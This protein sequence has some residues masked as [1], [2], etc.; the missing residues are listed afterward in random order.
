MRKPG[1]ALLLAVLIGLTWSL[2]GAVA[3]VAAPSGTLLRSG[4]SLYPR[5]VRL[6]HSGTANGRI[7]SSV[8]GF[9]G[10]NGMGVFS[11]STNDGASFTQVGTVS[12]PAG[13]NG[14]GLCCGS[15]YEL[16]QQVG[17]IPAGTL[18][19]AASTGQDATD[20]RM[21]LQVW[22]SRD[23]A[24]SWSYLSS[25]AVATTTG[26]LWEPELTVDAAGRLECYYSDET[27]PSAHSQS[28]RRVVSSDGV[29]WSTP[30]DVVALSAVAKR[31]GMPVV[32]KLPT[33]RYLMTYE[34]CSTDGSAGCEVYL[35]GSA[36]GADWGAATD[37][38]TR[39]TA[40]DG[41]YF[42]HAPTLTWVD[43]GT[44]NGRLV[45]VGQL[46]LNADGSTAAGNGH[47]LMV[48]TEGGFGGWYETESPVSVPDAY[49]NY[50]PNYSSA[51]VGSADG[52][53]VLEIAT[54]YAGSTCQAYFATGS[55]TGT[56]ATNP[57]TSGAAYRFV[58]V[59]SQICLDVSADSRVPGGN[60]QQWTCND[61]GPQNF[62]TTATGTGYYTLRG[63]NSGLC[64][65]I[66]GDDV[67]Q[68]TCTGAA[69]QAWRLVSVGTGYVTAV[70]QSS[71]QCLDVAAGSTAPGA[72]VRQYTCNGQAPQIWSLQQR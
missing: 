37:A 16:P 38:G 24:R 35:R 71:S 41:R 20:R 69:T 36:D 43:N 12:P 28:I 57:A 48:N 26:G 65:E 9:N 30:V 58:N 29:T 49:N 62:V 68:G 54:G 8:V 40:V 13:A 19:W 5:A 52:T 6:S 56:G 67:V 45:L 15:L 14:A 55:L 50:C 60:I 23:T 51:L 64:A 18:L 10:N 72:D 2:S 33:G 7:I 17:S 53:R 4:T 34:L 1:R 66:S 21:A 46:L 59:Q 31:P 47:T 32:R 42:A 61:L 3:A 70:N 44:A 22:Q 63:Q 39:I 11:E 27:N 25:C